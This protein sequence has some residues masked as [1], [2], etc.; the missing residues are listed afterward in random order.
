MKTSRTQSNKSV[1]FTSLVVAYLIPLIAFGLRSLLPD[2]AI[3][4]YLI[5]I[6]SSLGFMALTVWAIRTDV[7]SFQA[8]GLT[9]W[10]LLQAVWVIALGWVIWGFVT[11]YDLSQYPRNTLDYLARMIQQWL[12]VGPTE[13]LF[14][15][16]YLLMAVAALFSG[17]HKVLAYGGG[18]LVSSLIFATYHL[19]QRI[20]VEGMRL[21]STA[22]AAD[23]VQLFIVGLLLA[24]LFLRTRNVLLVGLI[25]GGLNAPLFGANGDYAPAILFLIIFEIARWV[26]KVRERR[27]EAV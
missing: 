18:A 7:V 16:G 2:D 3:Y 11:S 14:F 27:A 6:I 1:L 10:R 22:Y 19:P 26:R 24:L 13:E 12:F 25:H 5:T 15:R 8:I 9:K 20:F 17:K 4:G 23:L 21:A